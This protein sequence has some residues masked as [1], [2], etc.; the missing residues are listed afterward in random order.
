MKE[1]TQEQIRKVIALR[2]IK[3]PWSYGQISKLFGCRKLDLDLLLRRQRPSFSEGV[4]EDEIK[5]VS[6]LRKPKANNSKRSF[7]KIF[8][9]SDK[10]R[11]SMIQLFKEGVKNNTEIAEILG[12]HPSTILNQRK[13]LGFKN[14]FKMREHIQR[15]VKE[16][17]MKVAKQAESNSVE[18][19]KKGVTYKEIVQKEINKQIERNGKVD[20]A[21]RSSVKHSGFA[22]GINLAGDF[23][24]NKC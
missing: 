15:I 21:F 19:C 24:K 8:F 17:K 6:K 1:W 2:T 14:P 22:Y 12:V 3:P 18:I 9:V 5:S 7:V 11:D 16:K 13:K 10:L 20:W 4:S 23:V